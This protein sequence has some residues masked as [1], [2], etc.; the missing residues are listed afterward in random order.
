MLK[1]TDY[2]DRLAKDLDDVD[3]I[4]RVKVQQRNWIGKSRGAEVDSKQHS[5]MFLLFIPQGATLFSAPPIWLFR[6][7]ILL[8]KMGRQHK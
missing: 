7:S 4:D 6:R 2:A 1:I 5:A 8:L 3:F